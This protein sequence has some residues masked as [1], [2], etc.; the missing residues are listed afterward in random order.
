MN[1]NKLCLTDEGF[2]VFTIF[3]TSVF[4]QFVLLNFVDIKFSA[5]EL[6]TLS[7]HLS[8]PPRLSGISVIRSL[9]LCL[10]ICRSLF[11][12]LSFFFWP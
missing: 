12:L 5:H 9:V 2:T 4:T 10:V 3:F 1:V 11:V 6:I 7:E 8:S